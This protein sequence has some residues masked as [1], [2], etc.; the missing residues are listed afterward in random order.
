M[1]S[2]TLPSWIG[3]APGMPE[4]GAYESYT[5]KDLKRRVGVPRAL[6]CL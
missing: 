3:L 5:S 4:M 1:T 6:P 2:Q